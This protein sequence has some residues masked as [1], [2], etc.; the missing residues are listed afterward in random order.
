MPIT[1]VVGCDRNLIAQKLAEVV[2]VCNAAGAAIP[3]PAQTLDTPENYDDG[4]IPSIMKQCADYINAN[5][6]TGTVD[7]VPEAADPQLWPAYLT[8]LITAANLG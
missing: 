4:Q 3:V 7:P 1:N 2:A 6:V 8:R 5:F